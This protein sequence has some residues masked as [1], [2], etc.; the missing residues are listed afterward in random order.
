MNKCCCIGLL[1]QPEVFQGIEKGTSYLQPPSPPSMYK[2]VN[3]ELL[4]GFQTVYAGLCDIWWFVIIE[5]VTILHGCQSEIDCFFIPEKKCTS[6]TSYYLAMLILRYH[7]SF[8]QLPDSGASCWNPL[9][10]KNKA[11]NQTKPFLALFWSAATSVA[12]SRKPAQM[13]EKLLQR[14]LRKSQLYGIKP[15]SYWKFVLTMYCFW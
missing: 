7:L 11:Q 14:N 13:A 12:F 10:G 2:A 1:Q 8:L 6:W 3:K 15:H 9:C 5:Y 4:S